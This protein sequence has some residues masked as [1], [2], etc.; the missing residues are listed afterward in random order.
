MADAF[1]I[2]VFFR[3]DWCPWCN[4]YLRDFND[5]LE[6]IRNLGGSVVGMTS[7][8]G[9]QSKKN[10]E[11]EF[12]INVDPENVA[13]KRHGIAVTPKEHTPLAEVD[14]I[15][16]HGMAQPGVIIEDA[17]GN[18]LYSWAV[19]PSEAN[20]GGAT[21]R[22]LV[23]DIVGALEDIVANR[24]IPGDFGATDMEYLAKNHP[25]QHQVVLDYYASK[26]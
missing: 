4:G 5:H 8:I 18:V 13:A 9:N 26:Q 24:D 3:G 20:W 23:G 16:E 11:L 21:D 25:D 2:T 12:D 15:Y 7:Q 10:N 14:G 22:P 19:V 17:R 6:T 1:K